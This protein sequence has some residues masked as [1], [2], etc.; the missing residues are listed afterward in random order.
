MLAHCHTNVQ[1]AGINRSSVQAGNNGVVVTSSVAAVGPPMK[2]LE[3]W[4]L[5]S[6]AVLTQPLSILS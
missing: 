6:E 4:F 5:T 3:A 1:L 2:C